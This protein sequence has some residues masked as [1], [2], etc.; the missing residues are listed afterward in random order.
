MAR[1]R[2]T[3]YRA[4]QAF[5]AAYEAG[6]ATAKLDITSQQAAVLEAIQNLDGPSQV[7]LVDLTGIDRSTM[8]DIVRRLVNKGYVA[9]VRSRQDAR[10]YVLTLTVTGKQVTLRASEIASRVE[11]RIANTC[12]AAKGLHKSL[13]SLVTTLHDD[14]AMTA[15]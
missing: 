8:A 2:T 11:S 5:T 9:R 1:L 4:H 13:Q 15:G 7:N 3:I 12:P 10:A 6:L 14:T